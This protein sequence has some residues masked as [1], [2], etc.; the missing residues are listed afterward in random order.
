[1]ISAFWVG[2]A[3]HCTIDRTPATMVVVS[4][5]LSRTVGGITVRVAQIVNHPQFNVRIFFQIFRIMFL[6]QTII[7]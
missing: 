6:T 3:A 2:S 7:F 5:A 4:A 1:M